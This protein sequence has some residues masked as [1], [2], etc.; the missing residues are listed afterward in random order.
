[1][2]CVRIA[3]FTDTF[4][5]QVNGVAS[6]LANQAQALG[7][8]GHQVLIFTPK[9]D[10]IKRAKFKAKNVQIIPLPAVSTLVYT[11]FKLG[12]FGLPRVI[13]HLTRFNPDIL[14][15]HTP[16]T[17]GMDAV[18]ASKLFKKPL[19]GTV[20]INFTDSEWLRLLKYQL[21]VKMVDK[22]SQ[23]YLN[24][25]FNQCDLILTPSKML[26]NELNGNGLKK[27]IKY[28]PNGIICRQL[29]VLPT[30]TKNDIKKKYGLLDKV[31]FHFG[32]LSYEKNVDVLIKSFHLIA[33]KHPDV[34]LLIVGDGPA[35]KQLKKL[36]KKLGID[37][38]IVFTGFIDHQ[39][40]MNSNLLAAADLFAT[41]STM[42][43][44]PMVVLEAMMFGLPIVGV[45]QAGLIELVSSNGYLVKAGDTKQLA[46][47]IEK[48]LL[49][50]KLAD[51]MQQESIRMIKQYSIEK[52]TDKLISI[53]HSLL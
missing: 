32:R 16:L 22:I 53:Y 36:V 23:R 8:K 39:S 5:P 13:K 11:E 19:V 40:L 33:K 35:T 14:H 18:I 38:R 2:F 42:E 21:A 4:L 3:Y 46:E 52:T 30:K 10:N 45:K 47:A 31:V 29:K 44:H 17:I 9:L 41:A 51:K 48:I 6:A 27:P 50:Q 1:M 34:S 26:T 43:N 15:L 49:D 20:H 24:F 28:L 37:S 25:L 7:E 12:V